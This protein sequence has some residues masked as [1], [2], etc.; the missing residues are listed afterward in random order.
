MIFS[1][2]LGDK[3]QSFFLN[4]FPALTLKLGYAFIVVALFSTI[5]FLFLRK[6]IN[7]NFF[8]QVS[9]CNPK[10][11]G[12]YYGKPAT[13]QFSPLSPYGTKCQ[14]KNCGYGMISECDHPE[15]KE[16]LNKYGGASSMN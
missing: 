5:Y 16:V 14:D 1:L 12:G 7:E 6:N 2:F 8:F 15:C 10:C 13:F 3:I 11:S 4:K 9:K